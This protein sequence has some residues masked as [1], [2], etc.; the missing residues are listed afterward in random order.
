MTTPTIL[1]KE[2][3]ADIAMLQEA[4]RLGYTG[5]RRAPRGIGKAMDRRCGDKRGN[6]MHRIRRLAKIYNITPCDHRNLYHRRT[7]NKTICQ[8]CRKEIQ[9]STTESR[10]EPA[11]GGR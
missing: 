11:G 4:M 8:N 3:A 1:R 5:D 6:T 9:P 10:Q 7:D 2:K